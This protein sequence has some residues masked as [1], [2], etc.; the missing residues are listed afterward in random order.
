[1][2]MMMMIVIVMMVSPSSRVGISTILMHI[3]VG[4]SFWGTSWYIPLHSVFTLPPMPLIVPTTIYSIYF[5][6]LF[7]KSSLALVTS[8]ELML[9]FHF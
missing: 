9:L 1:M 5:L 4:P 8:S 2:M 3:S 6:I 7:S